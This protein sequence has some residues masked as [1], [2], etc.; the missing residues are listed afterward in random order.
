MKWLFA[1]TLVLAAALRLPNLARA[2]AGLNVDEA[3][4]AWNAWCVAKT[5]HDQHGVAW[6]VRDTAGFGQGTTTLYM[7]LLVPFYRSFGL[8]TI[9]T[10]LPAALAGVLTVA[11][12]FY[13]G[14]QLFD[15]AVG[16]V[17]ALL[18][19][20]NPWALQQSR[21]GHMSAMF[22]LAVAAVVAAILWAGLVGPISARP[23]MARAV[24]AG[25]ITAIFLY[26][27]YAIRLWV[28]LFL[29][30]LALATW[31]R[32]KS[33][34]AAAFA[35]AL[36]IIAAPLIIGTLRDPLMTKRATT[37]WVWSPQDSFIARAGKVL[38]RYPPHFGLDFLFRRGDPYP[39]M[40]LPDGYGVFL[41]FTLPL[42]ILGAVWAVQHFRRIEAR[43]LAVLVVTYPFA[44]LLNEHDGPNGLRGIPGMIALTLLAAVG[45]VA[46]VRYFAHASRPFAI[47][48]AAIVAIV[49]AAEAATF[50][51]AYFRDMDRLPVKYISF[52]AD[53][54][55]ACRWMKPRLGNYD[56]VFVTGNAIA[57]P[58]VYTLVA[59]Q[60]PPARW[61]SDPKTFIDGPLPSGRYRYEEVCLRYGKFHF[62]FLDNMNDGELDRMKSDG[63]SQRVLLVVRPNE[64]YGLTTPPPLLRTRDATGRETLWLIETTL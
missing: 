58:Y 18:L 31:P 29:I 17:A 9:T 20:V 60:Y 62:L 13:I 19:A 30:A 34:A 47:A 56:A 64:L 12:I 15:T 53:L 21:W 1:A 43:V 36:A 22:P 5:G 44:D 6:P 8:T 32:W 10:R 61:F 51:R 39:A 57:H 63:R 33:R 35:A 27:Y 26:G 37:T 3:V 24:I 2:P 28:P 41:E 25:A 14:A 38:A 46:L 23:R 50:T 7:Y 42:M 55:D 49:G 54:V 59:L 40:S 45:A 16:V 48:V 4:N 11:L 52:A